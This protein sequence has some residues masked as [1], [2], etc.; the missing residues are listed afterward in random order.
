MYW[1]QGYTFVTLY[2]ICAMLGKI[3]V[4]IAVF[5]ATT[6]HVGY[7]YVASDVNIGIAIANVAEAL[8]LAVQLLFIRQ[9]KKI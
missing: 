7:C 1:Q 5:L 9:A 4:V 3:G 6:N 8:C 2:T